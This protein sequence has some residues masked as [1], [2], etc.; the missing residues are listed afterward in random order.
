MAIQQE[1]ER[2]ESINNVKSH[3]ISS[4]TCIRNSHPSDV[5]SSDYRSCT[6]LEKDINGYR[7]NC[8]VNAPSSKFKNLRI[9]Q[10]SHFDWSI[11]VNMP[12]MFVMPFIRSNQNVLSLSL[13]FGYFFW[14]WALMQFTGVISWTL[15]KLD[16]HQ[17]TFWPF[18]QVVILVKNQMGRRNISRYCKF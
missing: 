4:S 5:L 2:D 10:E 18:V 16:S 11:S 9:N 13:W 12:A 17:N 3:Q 7:W 15:S 14:S 1:L 6:I 8:Q